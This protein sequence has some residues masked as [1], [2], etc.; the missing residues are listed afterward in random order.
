MA[1]DG[2][3]SDDFDDLESLYEG[4]LLESGSLF[5]V[6]TDLEA[7]AHTITGTADEGIPFGCMLSVWNDCFF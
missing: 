2:P 6:L 3:S 7:G 4:E 1:L 5:L